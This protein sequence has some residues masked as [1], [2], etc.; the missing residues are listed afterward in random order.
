MTNWLYFQLKKF[1]K[2]KCKSANDGKLLK[3]LVEKIEENN[4]FITNRRKTVNFKFNDTEAVVS[5]IN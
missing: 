5:L 2:D 4:R 3:Q 1:I